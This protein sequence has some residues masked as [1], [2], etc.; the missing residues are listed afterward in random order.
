MIARHSLLEP[1]ARGLLGG[2]LLALVACDGASSLDAGRADAGAVLDASGGATDAGAPLEDGGRIDDGGALLDAGDPIPSEDAGVP[3]VPE[4]AGAPGADAGTP[5]ASTPQTGLLMR[6]GNPMPCADPTVVSERNERRVYYVYCTSMARIWRTEDWDHFRNVRADTEFRLAGM[7]DKGRM[8]GSWWAPSVI[9][10]PGADRYFMWV[11]VPDSQAVRVDGRWNTRSIAVLSAPAPTGPW[12]F[13]RIAIDAAAGDIHIDPELF[14]NPAG[15]GHFVYWKQYGSTVPSRIM[16]VRVTDDWTG[17][18]ANRV[19][20]LNGYGGPGTWEDNVR[21]N[22]A[23]L[24]R[25]STETFHMLWSGG[26]WHDHTYATAH[27]IS[28]CGPLCMTAGEG[29]RFRNS[30]D[31]G[32]EQVVQ[33]R[34]LPSRFRHGGPGGAVFQDD[35]GQY[36][37][38]A[39]AARG[40]DDATRYLMRDSIRWRNGA[41]YV[42]RAG[43]HPTG[44]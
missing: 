31:R 8:I 1:L 39:A 35:R 23:L 34:D 19:A 7:S 15:G 6:A 17:V 32:I 18:G 3:V 2:A 42:D 44:F 30:G 11:S 27:S 33:A 36:I 21:E 38:Y 28:N 29:W 26:H 16:G 9:Y 20:I 41:P 13:E 10:A 5:P 14:L 43:H 12:R 37:I 22:P 4:D 40:P 24:Y 25:A